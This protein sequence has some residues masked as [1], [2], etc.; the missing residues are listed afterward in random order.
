MEAIYGAGQGIE[1]YAKIRSRTTG[2]LKPSAIV[3]RDFR[4]YEAGN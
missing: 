3:L 1:E 4:S 2:V